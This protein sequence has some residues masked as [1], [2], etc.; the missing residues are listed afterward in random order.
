VAE[1]PT[2]LDERPDP[3]AEARE[4]ESR[5]RARRW[6]WA[7]G[8][9]ALVAVGALTWIGR[10]SGARVPPAPKAFCR[11]AA[12]YDA[13]LERQAEASRRDIDRQIRFVEDIAATAPRRIRPDADTFLQSLRQLRAAPSKKA[14]DRLRD[15]PEVKAA[16]ERVNRY[17]NQGCGVFDRQGGL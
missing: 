14:R 1:V 11:A 5:R 2:V 15:D 4:A 10:Q 7:A 17:W 8:L 6:W 3:P 16:V 13:E 9:L 12:R